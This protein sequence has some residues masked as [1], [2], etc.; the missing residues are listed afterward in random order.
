MSQALRVLFI[1][2]NEDDVLT[3]VEQLKATY[4]ITFI[5]VDNPPDMQR[6]LQKNIYDLIIC[7]YTVPKISPNLA[8][9]LWKDT[10]LDIPFIFVSNKN[11]EECA[12]DAMR[13]GAHDFVLKNNL[14]RLAPAMQRELDEAQLRKNCD[15]VKVDLMQSE[16]EVKHLNQIILDTAREIGIADVSTILLHNV[17]NV[18]NSANVSINILKENFNQ[19]HYSEFFAVCDLLKK[20]SSNLA[21]YLQSDEKGKL[22]PDYLGTVAKVLQREHAVDLEELTNLYDRLQHIKDIIET[23]QENSSIKSAVSKVSLPEVFDFAIQIAIC[24]SDWQDIKIVKDY[25]DKFKTIIIDRVKLIQILVN[26][27]RNAKDVLIA[28]PSQ[29]KQKIITLSFTGSEKNDNYFEISV[30]DNG[31]GISADDLAKLF[32]Y[33]Y[34]TKAN[35]HGIGLHSSAIAAKEMGGQL[36]V[37]SDGVGKGSLFTLEI[38]IQHSK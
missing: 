8:I 10:G 21:H 2:D 4:S 16:H 34:T 25:Q 17:G 13:L 28:A 23:Q 35:G 18:L 36:L 24:Q 26:L 30:R 37:T 31:A 7:G 32:S 1:D 6:A 33:G 15:Q 5:R 3:I 38:P 14:K 27:L 20:H 9:K 12:V 29:G 11:S 22:I 19:V